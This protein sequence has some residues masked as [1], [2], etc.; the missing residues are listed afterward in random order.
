MPP[1]NNGR[2]DQNSRYHKKRKNRKRQNFAGRHTHEVS[3]VL[4]HHREQHSAL[5]CHQRNFDHM[6]QHGFPL[7]VYLEEVESW[8]RGIG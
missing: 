6:D 1:I 7:V 2:K 5:L 4:A 8:R 3:S